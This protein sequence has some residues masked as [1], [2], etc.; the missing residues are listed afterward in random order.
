MILIKPITSADIAAFKAVRLRALQ[1]SPGAFGATYANESQFTDEDWE[2]RTERWSGG[3]GV[4]FLAWD[5]AGEEVTACGIAGT[6]LDERDPAH[7]TLISMW[8]APT[9]RRL[10]VGSLL[11]DAVIDWARQRGVGTLL[12]MVTSN[13]QAAI[14]FYE[15]LG[16]A[17]TGRTEPYPNDPNVI[18][19]EMSME[20]AR[21]P[22]SS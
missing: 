16:F 18:E 14:P 8:T 13:N 15:R 3:R 10:G 9:H 2:K 5:H 11:V 21:R 1:E 19:Y 12:L 17:R 7:A 22:V 6:F 4:G 20:I